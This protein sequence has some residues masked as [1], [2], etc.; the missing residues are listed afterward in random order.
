SNGNSNVNVLQIP[1]KTFVEKDG[2]F[3]NYKGKHQFFKKATIIVSE[4]LTL[5]EAADLFV[6]KN[7]RVEHSSTATFTDVHQRLDQVT[8]E[9]RK[10]NEFVYRR[11]SL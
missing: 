7:L 5:T 2:T 6:G 3:V 4:A 11:G 9:N 1:L 8:I 10:K